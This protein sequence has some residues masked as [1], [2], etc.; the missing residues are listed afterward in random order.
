MALD[1]VTIVKF[2]FITNRIDYLRQKNFNWNETSIQ[3]MS[4]FKFFTELPDIY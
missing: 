4:G 3:V 1:I 2:I